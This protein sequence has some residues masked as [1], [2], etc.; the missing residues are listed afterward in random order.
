MS[1]VEHTTWSN[2][3][4]DTRAELE[5]LIVAHRS[6]DGSVA[7]RYYSDVG[8]AS[9]WYLLLLLTSVGA[10]LGTGWMLPIDRP[11][12]LLPLLR[13]SLSNPGLFATQ[14]HVPGFFVAVTV[15]IVVAERW[16][17]DLTRRGVAITRHAVVVLRGDSVTLLRHA[18]VASAQAAQHGARGKRFTTLS[19][20]AAD[21]GAL[22][23]D[24][25]ARWVEAALAAIAAARG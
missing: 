3:D 18:D 11:G 13:M 9:G 22:E 10:A 5:A 20:R 2:L 23:I 1:Q 7:D 4:S 21:G 25:V 8:D 24:A 12:Q 6:G 15:A 17:R 14:P 16:R 19:L